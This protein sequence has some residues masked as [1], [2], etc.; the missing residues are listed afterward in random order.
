VKESAKILSWLE[1]SAKF[2]E[3]FKDNEGERKDTVLERWIQ[4]RTK[5]TVETLRLR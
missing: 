3:L 5:Q 4:A 2:Y 1:N